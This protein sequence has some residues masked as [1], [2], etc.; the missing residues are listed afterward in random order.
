M[1]VSTCDLEVEDYHY[2]DTFYEDPVIKHSTDRLSASEISSNKPLPAPRSPRL[3]AVAS[4]DYLVCLPCTDNAPTNTD[5][6]SHVRL[7]L[8]SHLHYMPF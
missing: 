7:E 5:M 8:S 6:V 3:A 1:H 4:A 2:P